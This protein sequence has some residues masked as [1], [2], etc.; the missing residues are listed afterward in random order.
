MRPAIAGRAI[1]LPLRGQHRLGGVRA[2]APSCFPLNCGRE[3]RGARAPTGTD[4]ID[5]AHEKSKSHGRKS[6]VSRTATRE[7]HE[8]SGPPGFT[9]R[10]TNRWQKTLPAAASSRIQVRYREVH[11]LC[12]A[13]MV[14]RPCDQRLRRN[15]LCHARASASM[16]RS[17]DCLVFRMRS[18]RAVAPRRAGCRACSRDLPRPMRRPWPFMDRGNEASRAT[19]AKGRVC[20]NPCL[21]ECPLPIRMKTPMTQPSLIDQITE[22]FEQLVSRHEELRR[23]NQRLSNEVQALTQERDRLK[24]QMAAARARVDALIHLLAQHDASE[25]PDAEPISPPRGSET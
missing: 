6:A 17:H 9:L 11:M 12:H 18:C 1:R 8:T 15:M 10:W 22:R 16:R 13:M 23:A 24:A 7:S 5:P 4:S 25:L 19:S 21:V 3:R 14:Y 20:R 2:E